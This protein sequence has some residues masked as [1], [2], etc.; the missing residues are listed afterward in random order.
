MLATSNTQQSSNSTR[1]TRRIGRIRR[2]LMVV[3]AAAAALSIPAVA[4]AE[5]GESSLLRTRQPLVAV[6]TGKVTGELPFC[7]N[8]APGPC[9]WIVEGKHTGTPIRSGTFFAAIDDGNAASP[10]RCVPAIYSGLLNDGPADAIAQVSEG[11]V[12]PNAAGGYAFTGRIDFGG[13]SGRF[14]EI[15]GGRGRVLVN[16]AANGST[17]TLVGHIRTG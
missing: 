8:G 3:L 1:L 7:F 13:G 15:S 16:M 5:A 6:G 4:A 2:I 12:C 9:G 10:R 17:L 14:Q 11:R